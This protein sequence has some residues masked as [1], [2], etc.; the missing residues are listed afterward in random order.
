MQKVYSIVDSSRP[1]L[2]AI[3]AT[4]LPAE[5][6]SLWCRKQCQRFELRM[7]RRGLSSLLQIETLTVK[8]WL[9]AF[10]KQQLWVHYRRNH[11]WQFWRVRQLRI[12][13]N[14]KLKESVFGIL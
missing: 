4:F 7:K 12:S 8:H 6:A 14:K 3:A 5:K 13:F 10:I 2:E 11:F 1:Q 9:F